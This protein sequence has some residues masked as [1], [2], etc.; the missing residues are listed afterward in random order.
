MTT[1]PI[2][3]DGCNNAGNLGFSA[4][5][6]HFDLKNLVEFALLFQG[7]ALEAAKHVLAKFVQLL[8]LAFGEWG[9]V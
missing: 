4:L 3:S 8:N 5:H 7:G 6:F 1:V 2:R 9:V